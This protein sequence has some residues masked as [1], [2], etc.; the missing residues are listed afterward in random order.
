M[1]AVNRPVFSRLY[2]RMSKAVEQAGMAEH[3]HTLLA[4]LT[5]EV[6][7]IGAGDGANFV[8]YPPTVTRV[9][10]VEPEPHLRQFAEA[11]AWQAPDASSSTPI[12]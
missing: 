12:P 1:I 11:A 6:V 7:E 3:R 4:G 5:G 10:A 8:H 9:L 2:H